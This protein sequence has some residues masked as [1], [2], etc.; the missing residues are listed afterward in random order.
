MHTMKVQGPAK[1]RE[2]TYTIACIVVHVLFTC[3]V[4]VV[5]SHYSIGWECHTT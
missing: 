5:I 1:L 4:G 2:V 3:V